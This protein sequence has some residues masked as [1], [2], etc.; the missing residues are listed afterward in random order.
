MEKRPFC[1][2]P[3]SCLEILHRH[4][5][6]CCVMW[7]DP[8]ALVHW[9][10][11]ARA[12]P[13]EVWNAPPLVALRRAMLAGDLT[14]YCRDCP[15]AARP[16]TLAD[17]CD[18][19]CRP[20]MERGPL[21]LGFGTDET[22]NLHCWTCRPG[23]R[24]ADPP[25]EMAERAA[26]LAAF[27]EA[28]LGGAVFASFAHR[29]DPLASPIYRPYLEALDGARY[30][31][32]TIRLFT[33]GQLLAAAWPD[34]AK[35]HPNVKHLWISIDAATPETYARVRPGG[36]WEAVLSALALARDLRQARRLAELQLNFVI[37]AANWREMPAFVDLAR[38]YAADYACF[39]LFRRT[40]HDSATFLAESLAN[41]GH[42]DRPAFLDLIG[43]AEYHR[44]PATGTFLP[45]LHPTFAVDCDRW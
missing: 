3:F 15:R 28:F 24:P 23:P 42:A 31:D 13:W 27:A 11:G 29:G 2:A 37:R 7:L 39:S 25:A 30:R 19:S 1:G 34:L 9:P 35:I 43:Q 16:E 5:S 40:W 41:E 21:V 20:I 32:L 33:N 8:A 12:D 26:E 38:E 22:C 45:E 18:S 6:T 44:L 36:R 14:R 4:A 10:P 17:P